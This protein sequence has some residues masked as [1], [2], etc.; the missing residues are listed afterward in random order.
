MRLL[1]EFETDTC[2]TLSTEMDIP[3]ND[4]V[5]LESQKRI[6][7]DRGGWDGVADFE[8]NMAILLAEC[9]RVTII[10]DKPNA[11][12]DGSQDTVGAEVGK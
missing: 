8:K 10:C 11:P 1:I 6:A 12:R 2:P 4:V 7:P 5:V 3:D 9:M